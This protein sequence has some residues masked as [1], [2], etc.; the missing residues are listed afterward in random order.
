M[1][2]TRRTFM[3]A[4]GWTIL[5]PAIGVAGRPTLARAEGAEKSWRHGIAIFGDLKYP[6]GFG[7]STMSIPPRPGAVRCA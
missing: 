4:A 1:G 6:P 3:Q 2:T 7:I 5:A